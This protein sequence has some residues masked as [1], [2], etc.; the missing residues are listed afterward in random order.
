MK[1]SILI[2]SLLCA[3]YAL[4]TEQEDAIA[5]PDT[6]VLVQ[7]TMQNA[8]TQQGEEEQNQQSLKDFQEAIL[9]DTAAV[10]E[11]SQGAEAAAKDIMAVLEGKELAVLKSSEEAMSQLV[12]MPTA[13]NAGLNSFL[14]RMNS[15]L[16]R[17][18]NY[19]NCLSNVNREVELQQEPG[20]ND[21]DL[22]KRVVDELA[23]SQ[24][25]R[26]TANAEFRRLFRH[27]RQRSRLPIRRYFESKWRLP[28]RRYFGSKWRLLSKVRKIIACWR[29]FRG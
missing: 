1:T 24:G 18:Y 21:E 6:V 16:T 8:L 22:L 19:Y 17:Y 13:F 7:N 15:I 2:F 5:K 26:S 29:R 3:V 14:T 4:P 12:S 28:V 27:I 23:T 20:K 10:E 11:P 25:S 9:Q